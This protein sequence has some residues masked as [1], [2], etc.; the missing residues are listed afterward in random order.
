MIVIKKRKATIV[1]GRWTPVCPSLLGK[2]ELLDE[3]L[4]FLCALQS[5]VF[6][7][8]LVSVD[9]G[10]RLLANTE[11]I[12]FCLFCHFGYIIINIDLI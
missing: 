12:G 4:H 2:F 10:G 7:Q 8:D 3:S 6:V 5:L 9:V 11:V 1:T